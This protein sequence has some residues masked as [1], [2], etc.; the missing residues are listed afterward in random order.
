TGQTAAERLCRVLHRQVARRVP[1]R[2]AVRLAQPCARGS[3]DVEGR[4]QHYPTPQRARQSRARRLCQAQ[5]SHNATGRSAA[6]RGELRVPSRCVAEPYRLKS[7]WDSAHRRMK[8][9]AQVKFTEGVKPE[10]LIPAGV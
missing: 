9:G 3:G 8:E 10:F 7:T 5:C 1:Q 6:L 4:L 2:D